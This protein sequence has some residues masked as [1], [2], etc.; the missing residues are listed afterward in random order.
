MDRAISPAHGSPC[1]RPGNNRG[2]RSGH[3][4]PPFLNWS[5]A[6]NKKTGQSVRLSFGSSGNLANQIKNG[7]PFDIFFSADEG[8]PKQ[9]IDDGLALKES[10]YRYAIGRLVLWVP[11]DSP[12]EPS[13]A[14]RPALFLTRR[15]KKFRSRTPK[16]RHTDALRNLR[17]ATLE[18]TD[19]VSSRLVVGENISQAAQFEGPRQC[20]SRTDRAPRA[21]ASHEEGPCWEVLWTPYPTL[22]QAAV[23]LSM[24]KQPDAARKFLEFVRGAESH[25]SA[26]PVRFH[27][28]Q[29]EA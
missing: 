2:R 10:L 8:Y 18:S 25:F 12:L 13:Q 27:P 29:G 3:E 22:N 19:Q 20:A 9:L 16:L 5:I 23:V 28:A 24:S 15:Y 11:N 17:Y 6:Y 7:A 4:L 14:R 1:V 26:H 21:L